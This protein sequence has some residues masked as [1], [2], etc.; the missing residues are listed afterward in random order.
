SSE[1]PVEPGSVEVHLEYKG[2]SRLEAAEPLT[3]TTDPA[4]VEV[5]LAM[6]KTSDDPAGARIRVDATSTDSVETI[7][8]DLSI[9]AVGDDTFRPLRSVETG[10]EFV[11][12]RKEAG[13]AGIYRLRAKFPGDERRQAASTVVT[14]EMAS[15]SQ[16]SSRVSS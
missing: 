13:G 2:G 16:V 10:K 11:F 7:N 14:I 4:K 8:V 1:V 9:A 5:E 15:G 6:V 12:A 3:V